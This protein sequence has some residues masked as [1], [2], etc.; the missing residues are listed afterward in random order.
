VDVD[1]HQDLARQY[2]VQG[3]PTLFV[4]VGG[5]RQER[6]VG[7]QDETTLFETIEQYL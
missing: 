6:L 1:E 3:V 2:S 5:E 4:Y 7:M